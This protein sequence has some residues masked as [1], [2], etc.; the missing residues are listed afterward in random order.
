MILTVGTALIRNEA[1][2]LLLLDII[3][4]SRLLILEKYFCCFQSCVA[5]SLH[6]HLTLM[7]KVSVEEVQELTNL[8][9]KEFLFFIR[10]IFF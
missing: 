1:F 3:Y 4:A 8:Y 9:Y 2:F 7:V 6:N 5:Y 10:I